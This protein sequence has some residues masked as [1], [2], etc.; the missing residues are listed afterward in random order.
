VSGVVPV[1]WGTKEVFDVFNKDAF[2]Y[3]DVD[4][5]QA[6]LD[7]LMRL[8]QD[9]DAYEKMLSTPYLADGQNTVDKFFSYTSDAA[10]GIRQRV[11][12]MVAGRHRRIIK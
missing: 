8:D 9:D 1:Y 11:R 4:N 7:Q 6:S 12:D 5:P 3:W 2:V 10:D